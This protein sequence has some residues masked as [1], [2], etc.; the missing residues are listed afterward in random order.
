[1]IFFAAFSAVHHSRDLN[2]VLAD[3]TRLVSS[4]IVAPSSRAWSRWHSQR[5]PRILRWRRGLENQRRR[6]LPRRR[7]EGALLLGLLGLLCSLNHRRRRDIN[8]TWLG[9]HFVSGDRLLRRSY[10]FTYILL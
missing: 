7:E 3:R 2:W 1:V 4:R 8:R 6:L 10:H 9:R 5:P